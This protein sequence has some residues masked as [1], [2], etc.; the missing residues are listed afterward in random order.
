MRLIPLTKGYAAM[1]D[2]ADFDWLSKWKWH[3]RVCT[4]SGNVYAARSETVAPRKERTV[5]MHRAITN[6]AP[7]LI[8]DHE[9]GNGLNNCR[10]N[11]RVVTRA[12]NMKNKT[13]HANNR[14]G[15]TGIHWH[16]R[17]RKWRVKISANGR[18]VEIGSFKEFDAA[19][20]ARSAAEGQYGYHQNHGRQKQ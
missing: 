17:E 14:S 10:S 9:D 16:A 19:L 8:A 7:G 12:G 3:A 13:L 20:S 6:A 18:Q 5:M 15:R 11:L 1:V 2:D 4:K